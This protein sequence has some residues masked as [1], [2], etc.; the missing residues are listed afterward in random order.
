MEPIWIISSGLLWVMV[1]VNFLITFSLVRQVTSNQQSQQTPRRDTLEVGSDAPAFVLQ[2]LDEQNFTALDFEQRQLVM[3]FVSAGC[4]PC[5]QQMPRLQKL[6][7]DAQR[8]ETQLL[9]VSLDE[10][11]TTKDFVREIQFEAPIFA[12]PRGENPL[13]VAYKV[14][15]TPSYYVIDKQRKITAGGW[16]DLGWKKLTESWEQL[17]N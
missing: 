2:D 9:I 15:S 7:F 11:A 16:F 13:S 12:A 3:V 14:N 5:R 8:A 1:I 10:I 6:Y 4:E 17:G